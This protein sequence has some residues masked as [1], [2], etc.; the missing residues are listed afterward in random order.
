MELLRKRPDPGYP[1]DYL[2]SR[3][4][5]RRSRLIRDWNPLL[6]D[7]ALYGS[8]PTDRAGG[9]QKYKTA[10][11]VWKN[12]MVEY[13]WVYSQMNQSVREIFF[14]FFLY[15]ELRTI[16]I[17]LRHL[18]DRKA[19]AVD[20]LLDRSLL[21]NEMKKVLLF[22]SDIPAA[23]S[24]IERLFSPLSDRFL[25]L[26]KD[27]VSGGLRAVEQRLLG[28]YLSLMVESDLHWLLKRFFSRLIDSRNILGLY[29]ILLSGSIVQPVFLPGGIIPEKMLKEILRKKD[30]RGAAML[31]RVSTG[32]SVVRP[33]AT[34]MEIALYRG[35]T[36]WL[37]KEGREPFGIAPILDYLWRCS[38]ES[39]NLSVLYH[40]KDIEREA[41]AV[42]LVQ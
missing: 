18:H 27:Q 16:L 38:I 30:L 7:P 15:A 40:T 36:R 26:V 1:L 20:D 29:K 11:A 10:D 35:M 33:D 25:G 3:I 42:E 28:T 22:S 9:Y 23:V 12:L 19:G 2:L 21:S 31:V 6:Y 24:G 4:K 39:M 37:R 5:G 14:T 34:A 17:C 32:T 13:E 8:L 41:V